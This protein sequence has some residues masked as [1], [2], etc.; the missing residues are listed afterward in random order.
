MSRMIAWMIAKMPKNSTS[1][2]SIVTGIASAKSPK[3]IAMIP[4]R[5]PSHL[6]LTGIQP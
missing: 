2:A 1:E 6:W 5:T 4:A 3:R